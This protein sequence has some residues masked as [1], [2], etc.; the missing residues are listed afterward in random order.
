MDTQGIDICHGYLVH[1]GV[2]S[3]PEAFWARVKHRASKEGLL[4]ALRARWG[5][6]TAEPR[7][8]RRILSEHA[9]YRAWVIRLWGEPERWPWEGG[10]TPDAVDLFLDDARGYRSPN[11]PRDPGADFG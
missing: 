7:G 10:W 6:W 5:A 3:V 2:T 11:P 8:S 9:L 1:R 4:D